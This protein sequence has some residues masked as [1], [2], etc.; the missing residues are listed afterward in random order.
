MAENEFRFS[1]RQRAAL[2]AIVDT[3]AP[4]GDGLPSAS[5]H[6]VVEVI[7]EA[8]AS[9]PRPAERRQVAQLLGLWDSALLTAIGGGG[10]KR[11]SGLPQ[12]RREKVLRS[13]RDSRA[14]QR[15]GAYQALRKAALLMYYMKP[16]P[17]GRSSPVWERIGFP[18]PPGTTEEAAAPAL[19][20]IVADRD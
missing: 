20:P 1:G 14:A 17:D 15:R 16:G 7:E 19:T 4:G 2:T 13:W 11:F 5:E 18:G 8:V 10:M 12:E 3:F 9:N 6:G